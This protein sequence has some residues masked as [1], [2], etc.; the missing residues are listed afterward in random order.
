MTRR[1]C[2]LPTAAWA[3]ALCAGV[4]CVVAIP[5]DTC[6]PFNAGNNFADRVVERTTC[7]DYLGPD[8]VDAIVSHELDYDRKLPLSL[9][10][11]GN[12]SETLRHSSNVL[13]ATYFDHAS[14]ATDRLVHLDIHELI[15]SKESKKDVHAAIHLT[16][17]NLIKRCPRRN[18]LVL[19]NIHLI[20]Q[21]WL[22]VLDVFL[23]PLSGRIPSLNGK[24]HS[25]E[26]ILDTVSTVF[27]FLFET[28][29]ITL[30]ATKPLNWKEYLYTQWRFP[31][32]EFT[33][34][35]LIGRLGHGMI[36]SHAVTV[37][38]ECASMLS[39]APFI[40]LGILWQ[41]MTFLVGLVVAVVVG[42][43]GVRR[44]GLTARKQRV[45]NE[46][47]MFIRH[48]SSS[49][50]AETIVSQAQEDN[51][52]PR[53]VAELLEQPTD[54]TIPT[55]LISTLSTDSKSGETPVTTVPCS[56]DAPL[57]TDPQCDE[58]ATTASLLSTSLPGSSIKDP[59]A[60]PDVPKLTPRRSG[61]SQKSAPKQSQSNA[62]SKKYK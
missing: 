11:F 12:S 14:T 23:Q 15:Q 33:P 3:W 47:V 60:I 55:P 13:A 30:E 42:W 24:G 25:D 37:A 18:M 41:L 43:F 6:S 54:N 8:L 58:V 48:S 46:D 61:R 21:A 5:Q 32:V 28:D 2:K 1:W 34:Q 53:D 17:A 36:V 35:A 38:P 27:V 39:H 29:A 44:K 26:G 45:P 40:G 20:P 9:V 52:P 49:R 22:P 10:L 19:Q 62:N 59:R 56:I 51:A 16:L 4:G 57:A 50:P 7:L 31:G